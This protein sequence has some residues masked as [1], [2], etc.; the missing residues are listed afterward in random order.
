MLV[1]MR[2]WICGDADYIRHDYGGGAGGWAVLGVGRMMGR[3]RRRGSMC[4]WPA[5]GGA[6]YCGYLN[7]V[8]LVD[9]PELVGFGGVGGSGSVDGV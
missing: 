6:L 9:D 4:C 3:C 5:G 1:I 7:K 2:M 8:D